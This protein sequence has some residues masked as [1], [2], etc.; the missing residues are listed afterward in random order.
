[1]IGVRGSAEAGTNKVTCQYWNPVPFQGSKKKVQRMQLVNVFG[2]ETEAPGGDGSVAFKLGR[3]GGSF[4]CR[5][6]DLFQPDTTYQ[7]LA[8]KIETRASAETANLSKVFR[9]ET[10]PTLK[11][12]TQAARTGRFVLA[13][14]PGG[15]VSCKTP[16]VFLV[17]LGL[18]GESE[19]AQGRH[20][21]S[22]PL[23][24]EEV[25]YVRG[26]SVFPLTPV[27]AV[28]GAVE[29]EA[30]QALKTELSSGVA[31][32]KFAQ[33]CHTRLQTEPF[34]IVRPKTVQEQVAALGE[35]GRLVESRLNLESGVLEARRA[36][37]GHAVLEITPGTLPASLEPGQTLSVTL[38]E[39]A[40]A[41]LGL[42]KRSV[43][44]DI[45]VLERSVNEADMASVRATPPSPSAHNA[46]LDYLP[47]V[48][49]T[50]QPPYDSRLSG[51]GATSVLAYYNVHGEMT[52]GPPRDISP[53]FNYIS[54]TFIKPNETEM[55]FKTSTDIHAW[56]SIE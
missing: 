43:Y 24:A 13:L 49:L 15:S 26:R 45:S 18:E 33:K 31:V 35:I 1:M 16:G 42:E 9:F 21:F 32:L 50:D 12:V 51:R 3:P 23:E 4:N 6:H 47:F 53:D 55:L 44:A 29:K 34:E 19:I 38:S 41:I 22:Q 20:G 40:K 14:P 11:Y 56:F 27:S 28:A 48:V 30:L 2:T 52:P 7:A 46:M 39:S 5:L 37:S 10:F 17:L 25:R 54:L 8:E 36:R